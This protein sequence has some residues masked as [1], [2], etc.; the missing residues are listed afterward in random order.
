ME[1]LK[2]KLF[3]YAC[4]FRLQISYT[5]QHVNNI[6]SLVR[7]KFRNLPKENLQI[8]KKNFSYIEQNNF[9]YPTNPYTTF[10]KS[11]IKNKK[12]IDLKPKKCRNL[13]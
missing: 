7:K 11:L 4:S 6:N 1:Q 2:V 3:I 12:L 9:R 8:I 10:L 13:T 5:F